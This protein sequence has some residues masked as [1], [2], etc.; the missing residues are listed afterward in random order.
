M[1][2]DDC[3]RKKK[4][5]NHNSNTPVQGKSPTAFLAEKG[6]KGGRRAL[7]GRDRREGGHRS[8]QLRSLEHGSTNTWRENPPVVWLVCSRKN[9]AHGGAHHATSCLRFSKFDPRHRRAR[10]AG[11]QVECGSI[12]L[13]LSLHSGS[14]HVYETSR[15]MGN[16]RCAERTG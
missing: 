1:D 8:R 2:V 14:T 5:G 10:G 11:M 16:A 13:L 6:E 4:A 12:P 7:T 15:T 3:S 9:R